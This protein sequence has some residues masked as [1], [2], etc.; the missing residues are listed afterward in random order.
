M[1]LTTLALTPLLVAC[2]GPSARRDGADALAATA[3]LMPGTVPAG[4]FALAVWQRTAKASALSLYIEGDGLAWLDR[5][6]PSPDP[7]PVEPVALRLAALD[8]TPA[9]A[10][11]ARPCQY[12]RAAPQPQPLCDDPR[13]WTERRFTPATLAAL[14]QAVDVLK[15]RAGAERLHL[16]GFSGG[17]ALATLLAARRSDVAS[18]RTVAGNL[19]PAWIDRLHGVDTPSGTLSPLAGA[20]RLSQVPQIHFS[21]LRDRVVPPEIAER[22]TEAVG[23]PGRSTACIR[24]E[25][26]AAGHTDG[27]AQAWPALLARP[28]P[29]CDAG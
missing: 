14:E 21:G 10:V 20:E 4:P 6:R 11:L 1:L 13:W 18:L 5:S 3:G 15:E 8:P 27:W 7:T 26:T 12:R 22:F 25:R 23:R 9:V 28:L 16:I 2:A 24:H 29:A 17:G 19:E